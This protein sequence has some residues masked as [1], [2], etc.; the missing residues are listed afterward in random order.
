MSSH[1]PIRPPL[2]EEYLTRNGAPFITRPAE[3]IVAIVS[4]DGYETVDMTEKQFFE[5][6]QEMRLWV[7]ATCE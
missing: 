7:E 2:T 6:Y 3:G 4:G 1:K 5:L